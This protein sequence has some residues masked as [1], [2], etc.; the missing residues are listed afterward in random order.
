[1]ILISLLEKDFIVYSE[2]IFAFRKCDL[3][4]CL[5]RCG[6]RNKIL[7]LRICA[8]NKSLSGIFNGIHAGI[9][10]FCQLKILMKYI[11]HAVSLEPI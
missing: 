2:E 10:E 9:Q 4:G 7:P 5:T 11:K 3:Q 1:M 8:I 6:I